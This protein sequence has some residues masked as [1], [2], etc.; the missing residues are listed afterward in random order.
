MKQSL[1]LLAFSLTLLG[2]TGAVRAEDTGNALDVQVLQAWYGNGINSTYGFG[3]RSY[4]NDQ[5]S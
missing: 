5:K 4:G 2:L 1:G 3:V